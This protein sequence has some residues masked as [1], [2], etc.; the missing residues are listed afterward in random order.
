MGM[1]RVV[2]VDLHSGQIQVNY[3]IIDSS[4]YHLLPFSQNY[5]SSLQ[6]YHTSSIIFKKGFFNIPMDNLGAWSVAARYFSYALPPLSEPNRK[7]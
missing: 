7:V 2:S 1:D 6:T 5:L 4:F 3:H